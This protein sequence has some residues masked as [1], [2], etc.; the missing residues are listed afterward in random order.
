MIYIDNED[1]SWQRSRPSSVGPE[2]LTML[3]DTER[4]RKT[5]SG[6]PSLCTPY[7]AS[8]YILLKDL[9][10]IDSVESHEYSYLL[11]EDEVDPRAHF[12]LF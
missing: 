9:Y 6:G 11:V 10:Y 5:S 2:D 12:L 7:S 4:N 3:E 8:T 1:W